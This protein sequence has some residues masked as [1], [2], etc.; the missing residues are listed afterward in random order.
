MTKNVVFKL[1]K[2][3]GI[4]ILVVFIAWCI[5]QY[6]NHQAFNRLTELPY[7]VELFQSETSFEELNRSWLIMGEPVSNTSHNQNSWHIREFFIGRRGILHFDYNE[8]EELIIS[9]ISFF[10]SDNPIMV[11]DGIAIDFRNEDYLNIA[12][13]QFNR[14]YHVEVQYSAYNLSFEFSGLSIDISYVSETVMAR[15]NLAL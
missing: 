6:A 3:L 15:I 13:E 4:L 11:F 7:L 5:R 12:I 10:S 8:M 14:L 2:M 9:S 1:V